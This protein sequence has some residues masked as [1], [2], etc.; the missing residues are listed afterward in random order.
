MSPGWFLITSSLN[1]RGGHGIPRPEMSPLASTTHRMQ[2]IPPPQLPWHG[3]E[4]PARPTDIPMLPTRVQQPGRQAPLPDAVAIR[5]CPVPVTAPP[6]D[7]DVP[8]DTDWHG[9]GAVTAAYRARQTSATLGLHRGGQLAA[10]PTSTTQTRMKPAAPSRP[11][12]QLAESVRPGPGRDTGRIAARPAIGALDDGADAQAH[13][14]AWPD[15]RLGSAA[16]GP[17]RHDLGA[18]FRCARNDRC[19]RVRASCPGAGAPAGT[20]GQGPGLPGGAG[21]PMALYRDRVRPELSARAWP[22]PGS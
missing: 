14:A 13:P 9:N 17:P 6:F 3:P 8:A 16:E 10:S 21:G 20:R 12:R 11:R 1:Q 7:P 15:A 22:V 5:Q 19:G 2:Q 4:L 18:S